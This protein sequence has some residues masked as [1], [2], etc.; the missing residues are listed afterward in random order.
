MGRRFQNLRNKS[1]VLLSALAAVIVIGCGGNSGGGSGSG[2]GGSTGGAIGAL[3]GDSQAMVNLP[4]TGTATGRL[5][6]AFLPLQ[7]RLLESYTALIRQIEVGL[8]PDTFVEPLATSISFVLNGSQVQQRSASVNIPNGNSRYFDTFFLDIDTLIDDPSPGTP[9]SD[10]T[11]SFGTPDSPFVASMPFPASIRVLPSRETTV[12]IFLNDAM[13]TLTSDTGSLE[14]SFLPD[15]FAAKNTPIQGFISDF[16]Q[17]DISQMPTRP[18]MS[19]GNPA[20]EVYFSGD[21]YAFSDKGANGYFEMLTNDANNP[22]PGEFTDPSSTGTLPTPGIY[23]T[24]V[25]DPTD[26]FGG[27]TITEFYGIFRRYVD[28][29]RDSRSMVVNTSNFEVMLMPRTNDD[30]DLQILLIQKNGSLVQNLYWGDARMSSGSFVAYPL[31]NLPSGSSAGAIQGTLNGYLDRFG[32]PLTVSSPA[33][34]AS[35]RY[36]RYTITGIP[37]AGF[38]ASGRFIVFRK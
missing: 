37:P 18:F 30:D 29:T 9:P 32:S 13:I 25:P 11:L 2:S 4:N 24:L 10:D 33:L 26:P 7:G 20:D 12:P 31:A 27:T 28:P 22:R 3:P 5:N 14:A 19:N 15:E 16:L 17:F 23:R 6:V 36:G 35:V 1:L 8:G 34:A 38:D 21:K